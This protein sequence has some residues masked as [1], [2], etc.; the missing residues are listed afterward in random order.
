MTDPAREWL[1]VLAA[2][3]GSVELG[4]VGY[5]AQVTDAC[6][7]YQAL[8]SDREALARLEPELVGMMREGSPAAIIYAALL[9][10]AGG[11]DVAPLLAAYADDRRPLGVCSGGC[12]VMTHWL[13][14]AT[15]WV[16]TGEH[17]AHPERMLALELDYLERANWFELPADEVLQTAREQGRRDG[18]NAVGNWTF[19]FAELFVAPKKLRGARP[20]LE[21]LL[22]HQAPAV[23][24]YAALLLRALDPPAGERALAV[25]AA[26]G[27]DVERLQPTRFRKERRTITPVVEVVAELASWPR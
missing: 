23:R 1:A 7:A 17:W 14:E 21:Q 9:L 2:A 19:T 22:V 10:R 27:G 6:R 5:A 15:R 3:H 24:L 13:C 16:A 26:A 25:I 8:A 20:R 4:P 18:R 11:R 12:T